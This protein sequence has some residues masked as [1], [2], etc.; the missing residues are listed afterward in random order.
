MNLIPILTAIFAAVFLGETLHV[1][2]LVGGGMTIVG[3]IF[4]QR[5]ATRTQL[6]VK[7]LAE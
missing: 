3:I 5:K 4:V 2:H 7:A 6:G 1:Y